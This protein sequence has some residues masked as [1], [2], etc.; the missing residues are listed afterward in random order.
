MT[1][2]VNLGLPFI[3]GS[4]AQKHVTHNEAL[5]ILDATIQI[6][7]LDRAL[8]APP[9][10]PA[11]NERH[12][13]AAGATGAWSGQANAI[14]TWQDGAWAF[15]VPKAGWC[16][17]SA[18]DA[19]IFVYD[20]AVWGEASGSAGSVGLL[21][22]NT[23]ASTPNLLSVKSN[24]VLFAAVDVADGGSGDI[25]VQ[26]SKETSGNTASVYFSDDY[27]GRAEFGLVGSDSF[28]LK[29]S[30]DGT[31]WIEA[32]VVDPASGKVSFP[33]GVTNLIPHGHIS[34][35]TLSTA[36]ASSNFSVAAGIAADGTGVDMLALTSAI[37]KTTGAWSAGS[38]NGALDAGS[39][40]NA[41][42]YHVHLIK[43]P[44]TGA[45]DV[46]ISLSA[47]TP[48]L[49]TNYTLSRR[50]GAIRTD[51]SAKWIKFIQDGDV[52]TWDVPA[53]DFTAVTNPGTSAILRALSVPPGINVTA[54]FHARCYTTTPSS[55]V[56]AIYTD[57][58]ASDT[59]PD[60]NNA[61]QIGN[62]TL[63]P[64]ANLRIRTD[65]AR[66]IRVRSNFSDAG[67]GFTLVTEGWIDP[68]GK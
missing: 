65:T 9:S 48:T 5:R 18:A 66:Q 38:G 17:W 27:S 60:F 64:F 68:R 42:W 24:S 63:A 26:V 56:A 23:T 62:T 6:A 39:I 43:R 25:R 57:P 13:V 31:S 44:D 3:E 32:L 67:V 37:T 36:G 40:A 59:A 50:I 20:G 34:G 22:V 11:D 15:V 54:I 49:P 51:G 21:G 8:T 61:Q 41:T 29:V 7:V 58:A 52:F 35:L 19:A 16:V 53:A 30:D 12:I 33:C 4:Q 14:A 46:L 55:A 28:K 1:D 47:T 2:T 10:T 45:V